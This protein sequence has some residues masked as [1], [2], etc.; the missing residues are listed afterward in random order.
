MTVGLPGGS[1]QGTHIAPVASDRSTVAR[2]LSEGCIHGVQPGSA[3]DALDQSVAR[4]A[5]L[6]ARTSTPAESCAQSASSDCFSEAMRSSGSSRP[7]LMRTKPSVMP[8]FR[9]SSVSMFA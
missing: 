6:G 7:Q 2:A 9:R 1:L 3:R 8:T 4:N 5:K